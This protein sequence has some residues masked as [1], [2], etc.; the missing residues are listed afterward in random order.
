MVVGGL[1]FATSGGVKEVP[2]ASIRHGHLSRSGNRGPDGD[3]DGG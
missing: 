2:P 1:G 3:G